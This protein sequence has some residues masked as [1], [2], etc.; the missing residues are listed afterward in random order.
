MSVRN[1]NL[2]ELKQALAWAGREGW[3]PGLEDAEPFFAAD[4]NGYFVNEVDGK[5][6]AVISVVNHTDDFAFLGLYICDPEFRGK[7]HGMAVWKAA[8]EHAEDR[9]IGLDGVEEQQDNYKKSGFVFAGNTVRYEGKLSLSSQVDDTSRARVE[10]RPNIEKL[11][12]LDEKITGI[13]RPKFARAWFT[14]TDTRKTFVLCNDQQEITAFATA[15]KCD[16]GIKIGPLWAKDIEGVEI[17]LAQISNQ[18]RQPTAQIDAPSG[19]E[20]LAEYLKSIG[21]AP[22]FGTARMYTGRA[23][24]ADAGSFYATATLELG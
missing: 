6:A 22:T 1:I 20:D 18:F 9:C 15:R 14:D 21:F 4:P 17:I 19:S 11:L 16:A 24:V 7:G 23:P 5:M 10:K 13:S 12:E 2:S 8:I 3:N